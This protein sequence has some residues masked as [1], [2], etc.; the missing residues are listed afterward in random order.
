MKLKLLRASV[1]VAMFALPVFAQNPAPGQAARILG[2]IDSFNGQILSVKSQDGQ[3]VTITIPADLKVMANA[4]ASLADIKPG[5][6]VGS[7]ADKGPDGKL[8]A[9]EVHIFPES[10]RGTGEGHRPMGPD[11]NR[12]MTNGT[13]SMAG[14]EERTMTNGTVS[15]VSGGSSSTIV[16]KYKD[17]EQIIEV[18]PDTP[19][20]TRIPGD[21]SLLKPGATVLVLAAQKDSGLVA[22]G[23][24]A[25]KDG[26]K[27]R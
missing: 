19:I 9:E 15:G 21:R 3:V 16:V 20:V 25:E 7:A 6:F 17:G 1:L 8:R 2:T 24:T 4:K 18:A 22:T 5:D 11:P 12:S 27:P 10:M 26:V 14:P 13:V 23:V